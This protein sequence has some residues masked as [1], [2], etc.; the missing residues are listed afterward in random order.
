[1]DWMWIAYCLTLER[2]KVVLDKRRIR[3]YQQQCREI[4]RLELDAMTAS[5]EHC[6]NIKA[7]YEKTKGSAAA[8]REQ[9]TSIPMSFWEL[10]EAM[11]T[12][13]RI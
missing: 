9:H 12:D 3:Y 7:H 6:E 2:A 1:M 13:E 4:R 11:L 5:L 8:K 10:L